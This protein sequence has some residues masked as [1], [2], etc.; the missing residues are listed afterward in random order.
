VAFTERTRTLAKHQSAHRCCVCHKPFVE[1]HHLIPQAEGGDD[2]LENAAPLC[3]SCHDLYGGNPEK[4]KALRQLRDHWWT[5]MAERRARVTEAS[6]VDDSVL[7][8]EDPHFHGAL[9]NKGVAICHLVLAEEDFSTAAE[10]IVRLIAAAQDEAPNAP[11]HLF[12]Y[13]E[14]H[15]NANGAFDRD[16]FELQRHFLLGFLMQYLTEL[17]MPLMV[18]RNKKAQINSVPE[19]LKVHKA[20]SNSTILDAIDSGST[21]IWIADRDRAIRL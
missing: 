11:R 9:R 12:L 3:A 17:S 19:S 21:Q 8:D 13:V 15:R 18:A 4:R 6:A 14:G 1:V 16:M 5:L 2:S 10:H 20:L 7:I